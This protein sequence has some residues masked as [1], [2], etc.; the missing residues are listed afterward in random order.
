MYIIINEEGLVSNGT[1]NPKFDKVG[2]PFKT[3]GSAKGHITQLRNIE[4]IDKDGNFIYENCR[5]AKVS[6]EVIEDIEIKGFNK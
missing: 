3:I 1:F 5:L 2:K 4:R 6:Y